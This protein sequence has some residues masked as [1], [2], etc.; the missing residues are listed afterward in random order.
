MRRIA[1]MGAAGRMG[2]IL[3]EAVGQAE[4]A[5]SGRCCRDQGLPSRDQQSAHATHSSETR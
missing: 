3:I 1:V 4:G 5:T 2:K